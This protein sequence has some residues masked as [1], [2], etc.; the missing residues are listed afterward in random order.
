MDITTLILRYVNDTTFN[1]TLITTSVVLP[2]PMLKLR[3]TA[4]GERRESL[5]LNTSGDWFPRG[6]LISRR[7]FPIT[8]IELATSCFLCGAVCKE[9]RMNIGA[10][11]EWLAQTETVDGAGPG[12]SLAATAVTEWLWVNQRKLLIMEAKEHRTRQINTSGNK[13]LIYRPPKDFMSPFETEFLPKVE[14][15]LDM[16]PLF[17]LELGQQSV[18]VGK[19]TADPMWPLVPGEKR[20]FSRVFS[21]SW[22]H[23][24]LKMA[25]WSGGSRSQH[26]RWRPLSE[27]AGEF[28]P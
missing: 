7:L 23:H 9:Y 4:V 5:Q 14:D 28:Y 1:I 8:G 3:L 18:Y 24:C 13:Y 27:N 16:L 2:R 15:V 6:W 19:A 11:N 22:S 17:W 21:G 25:L 12:Q 10:K 26:N 20:R